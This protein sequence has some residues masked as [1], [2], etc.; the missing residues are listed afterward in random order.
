M[1]R[2]TPDVGNGLG[3]GLRLIGAFRIQPPRKRGESLL[4]EDFAHAGG[5]QGALLFLQGFA[6]LID[7]MILFA[8]LDDQLSS[9]GLLGL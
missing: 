3:C 1:Q 5:A 8:Q 2:K 6:D 9:R 7:G 4:F